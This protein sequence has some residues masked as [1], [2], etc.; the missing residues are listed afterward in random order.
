[1]SPLS[2]RCLTLIQLALPSGCLAFAVH[3]WNLPVLDEILQDA[4]MR[5]ER[6]AQRLTPHV[7]GALSGRQGREDWRLAVYRAV[8]AEGTA[9]TKKSAEADA[10]AA[11]RALGRGL[12]NP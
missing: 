9:P 6:V 5:P 11:G 8:P 4:A 1:M 2:D 10:A 7:T 3:A 12:V